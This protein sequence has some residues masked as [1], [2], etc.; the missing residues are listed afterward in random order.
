MPSKSFN[1]GLIDMYQG[2]ILGVALFDRMLGFFDDPTQHFKV[3]TML[4][5]ETESIARLRP[6][7]M[8]LRL[9]LS[10]IAESRNAGHK[11]ADSL[12]G[13]TWEE[14]MVRLRDGVEPYVEKYKEIVTT[15]PAGYQLI[16]ESMVVHEESLYRFTELELAGDSEHSLDDVIAQLHHP[17][18]RP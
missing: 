15:A 16:A 6:A 10:E 3:A 2:E 12:Q 14:F 5:L 1:D 7:L 4:Q 17:L 18:P 9:D 8:A 13:L 11:W